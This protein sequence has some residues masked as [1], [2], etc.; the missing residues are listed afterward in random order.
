MLLDQIRRYG[1]DANI[2]DAADLMLKPSQGGRRVRKNAAISMQMQDWP[3]ALNHPE[4]QRDDH[5]LWGPDRLMTTFSKFR[6]SVQ[7]NSS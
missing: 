7:R 5:I 1:W 3:D 4:W 6:F 2:S